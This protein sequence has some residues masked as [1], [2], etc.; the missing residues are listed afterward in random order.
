MQETLVADAVDSVRVPAPGSRTKTILVASAATLI[1]AFAAFAVVRPRASPPAE[2]PASG[3]APAMP[4][5]GA[6]SAAGAPTASQTIG[7][8]TAPPAL[9]P[10]TPAV[11]VPPSAPP[12]SDKVHVRS[13]VP[14]APSATHRPAKRPVLLESP[15]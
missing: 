6:P 13:V 14:A 8:A 5:V 12:A 3:S 10:A 11:A 2:S 7:A 4:V 1:A 15:D 9:A